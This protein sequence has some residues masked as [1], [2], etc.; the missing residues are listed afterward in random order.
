MELKFYEIQKF[1]KYI[2]F[3][4]IFLIW[5]VPFFLLMVEASFQITVGFILFLII[6]FISQVLLY[7]LFVKSTLVTSFNEEILS[8]HWE[9]YKHKFFYEEFSFN[10]ILVYD[11]ISYRFIG[12]GYRLTK[13]YGTVYNSKG[14]FG[15]L[16][17]LKNKTKYTIGTQKPEQ[18]LAIL[19]N[20]KLNYNEK[21]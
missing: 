6:S 5:L 4:T 1:P 19:N 8:V 12:Y 18:I 11:I 15:L 10:D 21:H 9:I 2:F 14:N 7:F 20:L 16:L 13:K 17:K 3:I